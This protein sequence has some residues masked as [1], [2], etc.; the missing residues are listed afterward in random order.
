MVCTLSSGSEKSSTTFERLREIEHHVD[1]LLLNAESGDLGERRRLDQ[2]HARGERF[3][4]LAELEAR[5]HSRADGDRF[6]RQH[7][8]HGFQ[9]ARIGHLDE[10]RSQRHRALALLHDF[11]HYAG[12]RRSD[13]PFRR[14]PAA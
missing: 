14:R 6:L 3:H 5:R 8:D 9:A 4:P 11:Q 1:A 13:R 2:A 10:R 12:H 7:V